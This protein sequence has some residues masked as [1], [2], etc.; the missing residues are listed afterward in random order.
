M[1]RKVKNQAAA[2]PP[3]APSPAD[4]PLEDL[5]KAIPDVDLNIGGETVTVREYCLE[6]G[7]R[8]RAAAG[9]LLEDLGALLD[10]RQ[11]ADAG[12]E[13]YMDILAKRPALTRDLVAMSLADPDADDLDAEMR[14]GR[15]LVKRLRGADAERLLMTWWGVC[16]P[17]FWRLVVGRQ[18]DQLLRKIRETARAGQTSSASPPASATPSSGASQGATPNAS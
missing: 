14:R 4:N 15:S 10:S 13:A 7:L 8:A 3:D 2:T 12:F 16:G 9:P 18:R 1:A 6:Y 11:A 5:A 17:F